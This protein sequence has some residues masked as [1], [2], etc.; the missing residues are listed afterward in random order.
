VEK[1]E[2]AR[3]PMPSLHAIYFITP[4]ADS[5]QAMIDDFKDPKKPRYAFAHIFFTSRAARPLAADAAGMGSDVLAAI[6]QSNLVSRVKTLKE[7][8]IEFLGPPPPPPSH[9]CSE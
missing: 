1:L 2:I 5:V 4:C 7:V 6:K 9:R 8:N 3:Q